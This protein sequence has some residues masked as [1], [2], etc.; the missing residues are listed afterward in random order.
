MRIVI[1]AGDPSG[2]VRSGELLQE[3]RKLTDIEVSGLGGR[4]IQKAGGKI[5]YNLEEY[6]VMGFAEVK[7][8]QPRLTN[9]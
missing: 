8:S 9:P 3:L 2:D 7:T 1:S 5:I 6:S 4:H